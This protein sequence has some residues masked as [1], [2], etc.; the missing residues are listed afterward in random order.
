MISIHFRLT[1]TPFEKL[2]LAP[3]ECR[4]HLKPALPH[5]K[6]CCT[7]TITLKYNCG[8]SGWQLQDWG[9]F[10]FSSTWGMS[11]GHKLRWPQKTH[12]CNGAELKTVLAYRCILNDRNRKKP[13][14]SLK[15]EG[16]VYMERVTSWFPNMSQLSGIKE[17]NM[18][19]GIKIQ[20]RANVRKRW[21]MCKI[22]G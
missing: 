4:Y 5:P 20:C 13:L 21:K 14:H 17:H 6:I 16:R 7:Y 10:F 18:M 22:Q 12:C 2:H 11:E 19:R 8:V 1:Y 3:E 9:W 15:R